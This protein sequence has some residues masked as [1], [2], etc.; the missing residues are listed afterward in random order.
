[1]RRLFLLVFMLTVSSLSFAQKTPTYI[2]VQMQLHQG[3]EALKTHRGI[4]TTEQQVSISSVTEH[5][6]VRVDYYVSDI[7]ARETERPQAT[8][9][10]RVYH[11]PQG[12]PWKEIQSTSFAVELGST[13]KLVFDADKSLPLQLSFNVEEVAREE[14]I[15]SY[16]SDPKIKTC[17][18]PPST[19]FNA[20]ATRSNCCAIDCITHSGNPSVQV[21]CGVVWC[22]DGLGPSPDCCCAPPRGRQ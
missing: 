7:R 18:T 8:V 15:A 5:R 2:S 21:C 3:D 1:M 17:E 10:L 19:T 4:T 9:T 14:I 13:A 20:L 11:A 22:C 12:E 16:G 6:A